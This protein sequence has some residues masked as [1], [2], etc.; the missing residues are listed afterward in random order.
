MNDPDA[1]YYNPNADTLAVESW[2]P[3]RAKALPTS[4]VVYPTQ[5]YYSAPAS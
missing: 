2:L 4:A 1:T 3:S 5:I